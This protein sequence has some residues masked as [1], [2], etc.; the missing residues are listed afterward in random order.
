MFGAAQIMQGAITA[1]KIKLRAPNVLARP[2]VEHFAVLDFFRA[3]RILRAA[4]SS[5]EELKF[6]LWERM[7]VHGTA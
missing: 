6:M 7:K 2:R 4:E 1:K 3:S 5:K